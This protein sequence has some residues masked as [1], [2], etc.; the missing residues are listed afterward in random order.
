[1]DEEQ[2]RKAKEILARVLQLHSHV[3]EDGRRQVVLYLELGDERLA[4]EEDAEGDIEVVVRVAYCGGFVDLAERA[5]GCVGQNLL[6]KVGWFSKIY[7]K[8]WSSST[9]A[10]SAST[11]LGETVLALTMVLP[12]SAPHFLIASKCSKL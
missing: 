4:K 1:M 3:F 6:L 2:K 7:L 8:V 5:V 10:F 12:A 11:T 9:S